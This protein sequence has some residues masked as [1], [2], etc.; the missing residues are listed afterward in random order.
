[1][2]ARISPQAYL[3]LFLAASKGVSERILPIILPLA[4]EFSGKYPYFLQ[5]PSLRVKTWRIACATHGEKE[6]RL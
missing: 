5:Q 6:K 1:M 4:E 3:R 2:G